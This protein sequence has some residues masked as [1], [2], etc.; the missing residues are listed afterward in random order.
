M[1]IIIWSNADLHYGSLEFSERQAF[2]RIHRLH[3]PP[4]T[5]L[6]SPPAAAAAKSLQSC[7]TLC[8]PWTAVHQAPL[9]L[10]ISRQEHWSGL[11][12]PS[13]VHTCMLNGFSCV[14]P[15]ATSWTAAHRAPLSTEFSRQ[16]YW[17]GLPFP[18]P[19]SSS[20]PVGKFSPLLSYSRLPAL[21]C[22]LGWPYSS[23]V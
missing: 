22:L 13:P 2:P 6:C 17:S 23:W 10:G 1:G 18:S 4:K 9:S 3:T 12:F 16:E 11:P 20:S 15:C 8:N 7:L 19:M 21:F 14:R 5:L